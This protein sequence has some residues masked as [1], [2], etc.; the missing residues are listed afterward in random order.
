MLLSAI[1]SNLVQEIF[2]DQAKQTSVV[3]TDFKKKQN[4][5]GGIK[6]YSLSIFNA[7]DYVGLDF[8]L[9]EDYVKK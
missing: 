5:N 3:L 1:N 2:T 8:W 7:L 9:A 6:I 4:V